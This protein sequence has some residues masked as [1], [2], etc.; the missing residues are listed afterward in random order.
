MVRDANNAP[1]RVGAC[2]ASGR[3]GLVVDASGLVAARG[4][5]GLVAGVDARELHECFAEQT[6]V[7]GVSSLVNSTF[8]GV[9]ALA[10]PRVCLQVEWVYISVRSHLCSNNYRGFCLN[11]HGHHGRHHGHH[12]HRTCSRFIYQFLYLVF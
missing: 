8:V 2:G 12:E 7:H 10:S 4:L 9:V 3:P 11:H 6:S 5:Q 1:G